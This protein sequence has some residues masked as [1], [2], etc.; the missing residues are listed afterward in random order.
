MS[1]IERTRDAAFYTRVSVGGGQVGVGRLTKKQS[2]RMTRVRGQGGGATMGL[3]ST[4]GLEC[5]AAVGECR[6]SS[7]EDEIIK[8]CG[9]RKFI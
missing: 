7:E 6:V 9:L 5:Q 2:F 1:A 8:W 4:V 3:T